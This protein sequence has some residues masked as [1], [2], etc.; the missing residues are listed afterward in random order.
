M[1]RIL[2]CLCVMTAPALLAHQALAHC[3][4]GQQCQYDPWHHC[5]NGQPCGELKDAISTMKNAAKATSAGS[6]GI[7]RI[8]K[9]KATLAPLVGGPAVPP[10][11]RPPGAAPAPLAAGVPPVGPAGPVAVP[12]QSSG[13]AP[14][15]DQAITAQQLEDVPRG[16]A[17]ATR[18]MLNVRATD[19]IAEKVGGTSKPELLRVHA[20][21]LGQNFEALKR[22]N[23]LMQRAERLSRTGDFR[24]N[25][26]IWDDIEQIRA[27]T[28][29]VVD[30][31]ESQVK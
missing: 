4:A 24:V 20:M 16:V 29:G 10:L 30:T 9:N 17:S 3:S 8:L 23:I 13:P 28:Q 2:A 21:K 5:P 12:A 31:R 22:Y 15:A 6:G 25:R 26:S 18:G 19:A 11:A 27:Y 14:S 7:V 1:K